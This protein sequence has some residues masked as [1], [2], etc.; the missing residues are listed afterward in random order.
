MDFLNETIS[1][2]MRYRCEYITAWNAKKS[3]RI[4]AENRED[5]RSSTISELSIKY[6]RMRRRFGHFASNARILRL[7]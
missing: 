3:T 2:I 7:S 6:K 4:V 5:D 1:S